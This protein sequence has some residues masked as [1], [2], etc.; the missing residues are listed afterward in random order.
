[1]SAYYQQQYLNTHKIK[2]NAVWI[3]DIHLGN[4]DCKAEFLLDLLTRLECKT[5]YLVGDIIDMWSLS[6]NFYWPEQHNKTIRKLM[7]MAKSDC[8][9]IYIPGNHDMNFRDFV[10]EKFGEIE[11]HQQ[12]IHI[13]ADKRKLLVIHGDELDNV[14]RF[15]R[16]IKCMGDLAYDLL[17]F[18]NRFNNKMRKK[19][20]FNYWSLATYI[21]NRVKNAQAAINCFEQAAMQLAK[22]QHL[23][24]VICG[25]I[26]HPNIRQENGVLYCNDGDWIENCTFMLEDDAG[27]LEIIHW[28][29]IAKREKAIKLNSIHQAA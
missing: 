24:G 10:G 16:V 18:I 21:K 4:K 22:K 28:S 13:T 20:G 2:A 11:V 26:H 12:A 3:S 5:L 14:I 27:W 1:M 29:D 8:R 17:L 6:K 15:N 23:D 19:L 7:K 25:H 9:V